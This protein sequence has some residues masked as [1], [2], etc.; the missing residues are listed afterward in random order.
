MISRR[1]EEVSFN[2]HAENL[3]AEDV[4]TERPDDAG[5]IDDGDDPE[6]EEW[7]SPHR[8]TLSLPIAS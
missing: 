4:T 8:P 7:C 3:P 5:S 6:Q 1:R 2:D